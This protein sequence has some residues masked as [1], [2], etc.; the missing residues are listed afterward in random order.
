MADTSSAA[1]TL[2]EAELTKDDI[3]CAALA[4]PLDSRTVP[5][6]KWWLLWRCIHTWGLIPSSCV[7]NPRIHSCFLS[8]SLG[9]RCKETEWSFACVLHNT[10]ISRHFGTSTTRSRN[11]VGARLLRYI[12]LHAFNFA[13]LQSYTNPY[14]VLASEVQTPDVTSHS[15]CRCN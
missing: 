3:P 15:I 12:T 10:S 9:K 1:K 7:W 13:F 2:D 6:L 11:V 14:H 8:G 5:A 4:D